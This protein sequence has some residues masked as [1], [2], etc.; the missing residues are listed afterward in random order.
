MPKY[1]TGEAAEICEVSVRTIQYYDSRNIIKPTELTS[2][3]RRLYSE[4]DI[5]KLKFVCTLRQ[6]GMSLDIIKKILLE[7]NSE[8]VFKTFLQE[9]LSTIDED[10]K[11][12]L[13]RRKKIVQMIECICDEKNPDINFVNDITNIMSNKKRIKRTRAFVLAIGILCDAVEILTI[14]LW[15]LKGLWIPFAVS[16]PII[17]AVCFILSYLIYK[18]EMYVCPE[19]KKIFRP[20][21]AQF[22]FSAHTPKTRKLTCPKCSYRGYCVETFKSGDTESR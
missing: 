21:F 11:E 14:L 20:T 9:Q 22:F 17:I 7:S 12:Q 10:V 4:S 2:G 6:L 18:D 1:T 19:C 16:I 5:E 8:E 15:V 3:G 13:S